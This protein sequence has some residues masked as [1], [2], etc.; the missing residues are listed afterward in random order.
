MIRRVVVAIRAWI[1]LNAACKVYLRDCEAKS[2]YH[3]Y[4]LNCSKKVADDKD[5]LN[6][7]IKRLFVQIHFNRQCTHVPEPYVLRVR[8]KAVIREM[9]HDYCTSIAVDYDSMPVAFRDML[10]AQYE[11]V[12]NIILLLK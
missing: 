12:T 9:L 6:Q 5:A 11:K 8:D 7:A 4:R 2:I 3:T 10:A 1:D